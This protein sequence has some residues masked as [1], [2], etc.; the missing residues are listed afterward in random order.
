MVP[1][2]EPAAAHRFLTTQWAMVLQAAGGENTAAQ[3]ALAELCRLYWY[4]LYAY[5]RRRGYS[6]EDAEDLTQSFFLRL[7]ERKILEGITQDGGRFRSFLLTAF[8]RFLVNEWHREQAQKRGGG[9]SGISFD[10]FTAEQRYKLE[11]PDHATPESLFERRWA[12]TLLE[13]ALDQL[14]ID[15]ER[16]GKVAVFETLKPFLIGDAASSYRAAAETLGMSEGAVKVTI[17]RL[18]GR[19]AALVRESVAQTVATPG[20]TENELRFLAAAVSGH[21]NLVV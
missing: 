6:P 2:P 16:A 5:A 9:S 14:R 18:R 19:F 8:Q 12:L 17:H 21:H 10:A 1:S 4:P 11:P 3:N 20:E 7:L 13:Q 15:F